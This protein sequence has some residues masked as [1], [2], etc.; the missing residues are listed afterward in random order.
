MR[1]LASKEIK[2]KAPGQLCKESNNQQAIIQ[3]LTLPPKPI[4]SIS[5]EKDTSFISTAGSVDENGAIDRC[6]FTIQKSLNH[7]FR[8]F[9]SPDVTNDSD[10][11]SGIEDSE[12]STASARKRTRS[13]K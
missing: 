5:I 13:I 6:P 12:S 4:Q 8:I 9:G 2:L 7:K 1:P 11:D 3:R 10:C